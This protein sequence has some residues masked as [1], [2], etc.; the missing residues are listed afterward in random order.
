M[1]QQRDNYS[2]AMVDKLAANLLEQMTGD[3]V[4]G[5][6]VDTS[7]LNEV[8]VAAYALGMRYSST[9]PWMINTDAVR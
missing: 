4:Y 2:K 7:D 9:S 1:T 6:V 3:I 8:I 5:Y